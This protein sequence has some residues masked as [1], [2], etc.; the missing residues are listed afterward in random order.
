MQYAGVPVRKTLRIILKSL[1][2]FLPAGA[3]MVLSKI[4]GVNGTIEVFIAAT[5]FVL[6]WVYLVKTD[7]KIRDILRQHR[8]L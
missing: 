4:L 8:I 7:T 3:I 2:V 1:L 5:L 6:Y